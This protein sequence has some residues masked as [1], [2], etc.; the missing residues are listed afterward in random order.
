MT[1]DFSLNYKFNTWKFQV[2]TWG[3]HVVYKNCSEWW[4]QFLYTT[5]CPHFL[6]KEELLT[7][8]YLYQSRFVVS[9]N[10]TKSLNNVWNPYLDFA[11]LAQVVVIMSTY[12]LSDLM[13]MLSQLS[14]CS[15]KSGRLSISKKINKI[16]YIQLMEGFQK[17][18]G[19]WNPSC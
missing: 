5:C 12:L 1:T 14:S 7:M 15:Q 13:I 6:Q 9:R 17:Y 18:A 4:K 19:N 2:Q 8:I 11:S 3:E 10:I 16:C